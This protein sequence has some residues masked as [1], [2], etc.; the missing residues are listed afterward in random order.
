MKADYVDTVTHP[1]AVTKASIIATNA[2]TR[3]VTNKTMSG[4]GAGLR[5]EEVLVSR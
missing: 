1:I 5:P 2:I 4:S 3:C